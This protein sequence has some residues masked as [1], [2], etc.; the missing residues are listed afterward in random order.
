MALTGQHINTV[1]FDYTT[2]AY[3]G[4]DGP[5]LLQTLET[6]KDTLAYP[7]GRGQVAA[8]L[9]AGFEV[10]SGET[11]DD[12][13]WES[14]TTSMDYMEILLQAQ[15]GSSDVG[16]TVPD[17]TGVN[18]VPTG[19]ILINEETDRRT[20]V[21]TTGGVSQNQATTYDVKVYL[22]SDPDATQRGKTVVVA[23]ST[24]KNLAKLFYHAM[25]I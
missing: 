1:V 12:F 25:G 3:A 16:A 14:A 8:E 5:D 6:G 9:V 19:V 15:L 17:V 7:G 18:K 24:A 13:Y 20:E 4:G 23:K 10:E 11:Q 21:L 2:S 22:N